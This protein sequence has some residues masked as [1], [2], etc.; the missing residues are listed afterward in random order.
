MRRPS[1]KPKTSAERMRA[2]R[3]R[4]REG[5]MRQVQ[6]WVPD[7]R[8]PEMRARIREEAEMLDKHPDTKAVNEWLEAVLAETEW[9]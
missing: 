4:K 5:G 2:Y 6:Y 1:P 8:S 3:A 7:L 9:K